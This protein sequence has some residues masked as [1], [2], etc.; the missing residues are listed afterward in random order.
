MQFFFGAF[1]SDLSQSP[2]HLSWLTAR[3]WPSR[4]VAPILIAIGL[5]IASYPEGSPEQVRLCSWSRYLL[6]ISMYIF[7]AKSDTRWYYTGLGL[8]LIALGIHFSAPTK[9]VLSNQY[10]LWFGKNSFAVYLI[11]GTLLRSLLP[12]MLAGIYM[13]PD[14]QDE[15][16]Y[17]VPGKLRLPGL[18]R[19]FFMVG[20]WLLILYALANC[21]TKYVDPFCARVT[22]KL[23]RYVMEAPVERAVVAEGEKLL[24]S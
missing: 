23:E 9:A 12:W 16:G 2:T 14:V 7:P 17:W 6:N 3:K 15:A 4:Y 24:P 22:A 8:D 11:H 18:P 5:F 21:W 10:F 20:L 13:P 19:Y 1:L